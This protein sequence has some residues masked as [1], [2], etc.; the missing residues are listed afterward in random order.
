MASFDSAGG[1]FS[2]GFRG[3]QAIKL[4]KLEAKQKADEQA[5]KEK[6]ARIEAARKAFEESQKKSEEVF[7]QFGEVLVQMAPNVK[8]DDPRFQ[9]V[10][11]GAVG[12]LAS[13]ASLIKAMRDQA[14]NLG[15]PP[16]FIEAF[17]DPQEFIAQRVPL[18][19]AKIDAVRLEKEAEPLKTNTFFAE[20]RDVGPN[21]RV[22]E[23]KTPE[24]SKFFVDGREVPAASVGQPIQRTQQVGN[25][26]IPGLSTDQSG[27]EIMAMRQ[28]VAAANSYTALAQQLAN[29]INNKPE[30]LGTVGDVVRAFG[31]FT[32]QVEGLANVLGVDSPFVM[33]DG[34]TPAG[35]EDFNFR[36]LAGES[37]EVKRTLL[38]LVFMDL[39]SK[40]QTG[41]AIS[42]KDLQIFMD[43]T[44]IDSGD[45]RQ[46]I[47][48][49]ARGS[50]NNAV[51][52]K[53]GI[54]T[55]SGGAFGVK[56]IA[57]G[58]ITEFKAPA[59]KSS[60]G[61]ANKAALEILSKPN[62]TSEELDKAEALLDAALKGDEEALKEL[63]GEAQKKQ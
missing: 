7:N 18:L 51:I 28:Q 5:E 14:A 44:G 48:G 16:E 6:Q 12:A 54:N 24:G 45:P 43:R 4:A 9:Q 27:R 40:G 53:E 59:E 2:R 21:V 38:D 15:A 3:G 13:H 60:A 33:D 39:N 46:V 42:D 32:A 34:I 30:K 41:R 52:L 19:Q 61:D 8:D 11:S 50:Q 37:Q 49:L 20:V 26:Q 29:E 25:L 35:I 36:S 63:L 22:E 47:A 58:G 55:R 62:P 1:G 57:P 31:S 23:R 56:D 10:L 17:P